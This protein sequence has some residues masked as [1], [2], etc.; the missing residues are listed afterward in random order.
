MRISFIFWFIMIGV[1]VLVSFLIIFFKKL[2]RKAPL[3]LVLWGVFVGSIAYSISALSTF[4][5]A[6]FLMPAFIMLAIQAALLALYQLVSKGEI[7]R[8]VAA[9]IIIACF[10]LNTVV[11]PWLFR[12]PFLELLT[13]AGCVA[14]NGAFQIWDIH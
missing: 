4:F 8:Y 3:N 5:V 12:N 14:V 10:A 13:I 1:A 7:N 6:E 9:V 11:L 2:T